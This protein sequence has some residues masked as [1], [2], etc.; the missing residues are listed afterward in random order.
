MPSLQYAA[1]ASPAI[2]YLKKMSDKRLIFFPVLI[3]TFKFPKKISSWHSIECGLNPGAGI[4]LGSFF[5][6]I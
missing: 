4:G 6:I 3:L 1:E 5:V 2:G